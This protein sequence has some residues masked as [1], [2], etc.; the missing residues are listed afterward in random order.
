MGLEPRKN[1]LALLYAAEKL[2]REQLAFELRFIAGSGWGDEALGRIAELRARGRPVTI[3]T[4]LTESELESAYRQAR[5]SVF[6]S[7]HEGYG[8]PVAESLAMGTPVITTNYWEH[9]G[10]RD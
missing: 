5:F 6:A 9:Q 8:L 1:P 7:L 10:D 3:A 2:W 4:A